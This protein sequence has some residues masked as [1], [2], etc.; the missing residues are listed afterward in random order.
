MKLMKTKEM[1]NKN[2]TENEENNKNN[3]VSHAIQ[4]RDPLY[5]VQFIV[6]DKYIYILIKVEK[7]I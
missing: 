2:E 7:L 1:K 3:K 4:F 5:P 6:M